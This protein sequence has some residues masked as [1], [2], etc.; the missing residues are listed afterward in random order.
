M[1]VAARYKAEQLTWKIYR[2]KLANKVQEVIKQTK[3]YEK[4]I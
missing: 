1:G 4:K 2:E 3:D